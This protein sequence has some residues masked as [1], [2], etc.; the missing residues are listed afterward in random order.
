MEDNNQQA[1]TPSDIIHKHSPDVYAQGPVYSESAYSYSQVKQMLAEYASSICKEKDE[2]MAKLKSKQPNII[3]NPDTIFI[4]DKTYYSENYLTTMMGRSKSKGYSE[5]Q[6]TEI[7]KAE[8]IECSLC[9]TAKEELSKLREENKQQA[10]LLASTSD[11]LGFYMN[12]AKEWCTRSSKLAGA[13]KRFVDDFEGDF[14]VNGEVVDQPSK[15]YWSPIEDIYLVQKEILN[16][17]NQ[18]K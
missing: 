9:N 18:S 3:G 8:V 14:V 10:L 2:E 11:S 7:H 12:E 15:H 1:V 13:L 6:K 16:A 17:Y 5:G 4:S